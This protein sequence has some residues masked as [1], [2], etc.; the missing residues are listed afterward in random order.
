MNTTRR[1]IQFAFLSATLIGVY[2]FGAN[3]EMWCPFGGV[4]AIY[5]YINRGTMVCSLGMS[6]FYALAGVLVLA[7]LARRAFCG[8]VCPI[9]TICEWLNVFSRRT[10][11]T[12]RLGIEGRAV[13]PKL[14]RVLGLLKYAV[15]GVILYF[16][17]RAGELI[18]RGF[19][20]CYALISRHGTDITFWAYIV[21]GTIVVASLMIV[22]PFC[23][24][25]CPLA[26]VLSPL[27]SVGFFRVKRNASSC[28]DCGRCAKACP[29]SIPVDHLDQ[30]TAA[31]CLSCTKCIDA[32][33]VAGKN[34][35]EKSSA[36][37]AWGP[38]KYL[39]GSWPR[40]ILAAVVLLCVGA[41]VAATYVY[42]LPS[43][44][45]SHGVEPATT[46]SVDLT[47]KNLS[48]R[49]RANLLFYFLERDDMFEL[50]GYF[51]LEAWPG[52]G[53]AKIRVWYD[54]AK[55][56]EQQIKT[57]ITESYFELDYGWRES[58]FTIKGY[59][60]LEQFD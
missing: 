59:D 48:C 10:G 24:W 20:P 19:D 13:P 17:W 60:I 53:E 43:Y 9:G 41:T 45:K 57:A 23:R 51:R 3:C 31:R 15:L 27:S 5:E 37:L 33:P 14:D 58:P 44:V 21:A 22:M 32:C 35:R 4:E 38:P 8:Y 46:A 52:P 40:G 26:A 6:N 25:F 34:A 42:P 18:F 11:I 29:T 2:V 56:D 55:I 50:P 28:I 39:G 7:I 30:V 54:P 49:G 36:A 47:L 12:K 16:T 1:I